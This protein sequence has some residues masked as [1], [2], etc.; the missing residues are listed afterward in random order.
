MVQ[1]LSLQ[2]RDGH[3][4]I[5]QLKNQGVADWQDE[6]VRGGVAATHRFIPGL[7]NAKIKKQVCFLGDKQHLQDDCKGG[8]AIG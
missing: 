5:S 1:D 8:F 2:L 4:P 6:F 3:P 7:S